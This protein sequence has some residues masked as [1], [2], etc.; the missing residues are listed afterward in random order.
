L[1]KSNVLLLLR[2][3]PRGKT[4]GNTYIFIRK[5]QE[6][7]QQIS[8][9]TCKFQEI[10]ENTRKYKEIPKN[11]LTYLKYFH[12]RKYRKYQEISKISGNTKVFQEIPINFR[13][14]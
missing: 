7:F 8:G 5:Y 3:V 10:V 1:R 14:Y 6:K 9:N 2:L 11:I 4:P 12:F 13:K